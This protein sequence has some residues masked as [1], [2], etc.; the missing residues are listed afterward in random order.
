MLLEHLRDMSSN[1]GSTSMKF[2]ILK[3]NGFVHILNMIL[4]IQWKLKA[5]TM[6]NGRGMKKKQDNFHYSLEFGN[7]ISPNNISLCRSNEIK[8]EKTNY[9]HKEGRNRTNFLYIVHVCSACTTGR[10]TSQELNWRLKI[11]A[12]RGMG[13]WHL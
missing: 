8:Q 10:Y 4:F 12:H 2:P 11:Y 5:N 6:L 9:N 7:N 1:K 13:T 3:L